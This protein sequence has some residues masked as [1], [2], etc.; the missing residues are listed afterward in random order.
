[1]I[2]IYPAIII[3]IG[4]H[5]DNLQKF[6]KIKKS[7]F[8]VIFLIFMIYPIFSIIEYTESIPYSPIKTSINGMKEE[9]KDINVIY[10][11]TRE[12]RQSIFL[13]LN[14]YVKEN[15]ILYSDFNNINASKG[16]A[17]VTFDSET[18][19]IL[20]KSKEYNLVKVEKYAA[21]FKKISV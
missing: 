13:Y 16:D 21:L 2:P 8:I 4:Y 19:N 3:L 20:N 6:L 15:V 5:L 1:M 17:V 11:H 10:I 18:F 7:I 9:L 14:S 12:N